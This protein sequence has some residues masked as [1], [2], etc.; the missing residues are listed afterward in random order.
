MGLG[1]T[2]SRSSLRHW[3]RTS[4]SPKIRRRRERIASCNAQARVSR[5]QPVGPAMV[6]SAMAVMKPIWPSGRRRGSL[7]LDSRME[8]LEVLRNPSC[9]DL[10][11]AAASVSVALR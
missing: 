5:A 4:P 9:A 11:A 2:G 8:A 3:K 10:E 6:F 1:T 7:C